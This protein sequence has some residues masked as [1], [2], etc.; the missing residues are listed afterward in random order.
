MRGVQPSRSGKTDR[1]APLCEFNVSCVRTVIVPYVI[2]TVIV[3]HVRTVIGSRITAAVVVVG[4]V[5][6][7]VTPSVALLVY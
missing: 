5:I 1:F 3:P 7:R 6:L 2:S 4:C